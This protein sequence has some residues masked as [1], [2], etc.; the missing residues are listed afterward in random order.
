MIR[1]KVADLAKIT[2]ISFGQD[3]RGLS[4]KVLGIGSVTQQG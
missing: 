1:S 2:L 3:F 4:M